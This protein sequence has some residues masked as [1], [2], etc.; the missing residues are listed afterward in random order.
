MLLISMDRRQAE[1]PFNECG[2]RRPGQ[3]RTAG[4]LAAA[5]GLCS[6]NCGFRYIRMH[7]L[8]TDDMGVYK[9]D[10]QGNLVYNFI[11]DAL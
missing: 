8:L 2:R 9:E 10:R 1:H 3:R 11:I 5:A 7:G 6:Q 4:R